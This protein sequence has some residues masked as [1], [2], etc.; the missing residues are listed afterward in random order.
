VVAAAYING[1]I[2]FHLDG[3]Q[4]AIAT[5]MAR[6][7]LQCPVRENSNLRLCVGSVRKGYRQELSKSPDLIATVVGQPDFIGKLFQ[8]AV[9]TVT[10]WIRA[11]TRVSAQHVIVMLDVLGGLGLSFRVGSIVRQD[12]M[13]LPEQ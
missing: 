8:S 4:K 2:E 10:K 1:G 11:L 3:I 9:R 5:F 13:Y 12:I 7:K 6:I